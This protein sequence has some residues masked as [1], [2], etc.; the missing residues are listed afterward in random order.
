MTTTEVY[1][2]ADLAEM[3]ERRER[4]NNVN[5]IRSQVFQ[6]TKEEAEKLIDPT[7]TCEECGDL[8]LIER[9]RANPIAK[10]CVDCQQWHNDQEARKRRLMGPSIVKLLD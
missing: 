1:D 6:G 5:Q 9:Q 3:V 2:E 7:K 8:I 4:D 10:Y